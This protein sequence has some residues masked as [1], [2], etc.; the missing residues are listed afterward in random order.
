[1]TTA[2]L[3][4]AD[5]HLRDSV[6]QELEWDSQFDASAVGVVAHDG[7]VTLTGYIDTYS[8]KLAAERAVKRVRGVRAVANDIEVRLGIE[9]TDADIATD[10][11]HALNLRAGFPESVQAVVHGGHI[12]LSGT[13]PTLFQRAVAEKA[14]HHIKGVKGI[15]N[16]ITVAPS[17][18]STDPAAQIAGA[19]RRESDVNADGIEVTLSGDTAVLKG[20]VRS[21]R[22][23][24]T[25]ERAA[26]HSPGISHL[27]NLLVVGEENEVG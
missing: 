19:L 12:T 3:N 6:M 20:T 23:R 16:R 18:T 26:M 4:V 9:R 10:A 2:Q 5:V 1:M 8:G 11:A 17:A 13:V 24:E 21:W 15:V 7:M 25:V 14:V 27:V 22:E